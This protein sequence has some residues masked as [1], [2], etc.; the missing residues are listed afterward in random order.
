MNE[1]MSE[2]VPPNDVGAEEAVLGAMLLSVDA[3]RRVRSKLAAGDFYR[4]AHSLIFEAISA[5]H[6]AGEPA[7]AITLEARLRRGGQLADVGGAPFLHTLLEAPP[8]T[9]NADYYARI[10]GEL[11]GRR[12]VIDIAVQAMQ[13]FYEDRH[14]HAAVAQDLAGKLG[15]AMNGGRS[16]KKEERSDPPPAVDRAMFRGILGEIVEKADPTTEAD[17]VGVYASLLA[18]AGALV[19]PGPH[20]Q[21]GNTSHPLLIWPLLFGRTGSGRKGEGTETGEL[22]LLSSY[23][24]Y[25]DLRVSGLSS[26]EGLIERIRDQADADDEG[27]TEDKRLLVVE[28]EFSSV[29]AR[30]KREGSTLAG[31]L[32][33]A[34]AGKPLGVL[35]RRALKASSSHVAIIGHVTPREFRLRLAEADM[36]GGTFNR[37]LPVW[38]ERSKRLPIPEG[39]DDLVKVSLGKRLGDAILEA[40]KVSRVNLD[41]EATLLWSEELYDELTAADDEDQAWTEFTRRAAPYCLRIAAISAVLDGR[42]LISIEDL[43]AAGALVRYSIAS[44][45]YVLD[46]QGRDPQM[47]RIRRSIDG[48]GPA[49][50]SRTEISKLFSGNLP[51]VKLDALLGELLGGDDYERFEVKTGGRPA[52]RY[53]RSTKKEE[54]RDA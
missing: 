31:V 41:R 11:A 8:T 49:G 36:A 44:A 34:W 1:R 51:A 54:R 15:A 21:V 50:L 25:R 14:D 18:G 48:A 42:R 27:G 47:D 53:R 24:G 10:V 26:G 32:R 16:T 29:M 30:A 19:G 4:P 45:K 12:R 28:P 20:V 17:P 40:R 23:D 33:E 35:N 38:V 46:Q 5:L 13:I 2:R 3:L 39:I 6:D 43:D 9:A 37:F 52:E 22:F 7:D